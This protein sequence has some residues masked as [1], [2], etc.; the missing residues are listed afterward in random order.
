[1]ASGFVDEL[2]ACGVV[3]ERLVCSNS[4]D[5]SAWRDGAG[6]VRGASGVWRL[7][8]SRRRHADLSTWRD[9]AGTEERWCDGAGDGAGR[10]RV[11]DC[12]ERAN[13]GE[14]GCEVR[15]DGD[16]RMGL[17]ETASCERLARLSGD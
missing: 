11:G 12:E 4:G 5:L 7:P 9:G 16:Y 15:R 10:G 3:D 14:R 13:R 6:A 17:R 1:V 2:L 8:S